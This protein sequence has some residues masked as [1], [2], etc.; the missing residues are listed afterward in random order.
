MNSIQDIIK[1]DLDFNTVL[2]NEE[3]PTAFY[4][5]QS[6][7]LLT[8][9]LEDLRKDIDNINETKDKVELE[10]IPAILKVKY[11]KNNE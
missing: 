4:K 9:D 1:T 5:I 6:F 2:L 8:K 3:I 11:I 7:L 10:L